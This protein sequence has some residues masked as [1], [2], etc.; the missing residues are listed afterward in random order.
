[1]SKLTIEIEQD[2]PGA[3]PLLRASVDDIP[4][5][6][7]THVLL[8]TDGGHM[9][10]EIT[11]LTAAEMPSVLKEELQAQWRRLAA[12]APYVQVKEE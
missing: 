10:C 2:T 12:F 9:C 11:Q 7:L 8:E 1:M 4:L 3:Q 6:C 5:K